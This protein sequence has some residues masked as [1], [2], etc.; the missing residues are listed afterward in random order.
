VPNLK[1]LYYFYVFAQE[2]STKEAAKRLGISSPALSNQLKHLESVL[3]VRLTHRVE[4]SIRM[5][6]CGE[7]VRTYVNRMFSIYEELQTQL[8]VNHSIESGVVRVGVC[9]DLGARFSFDLIFLLES[10]TSTFAKTTKVTFGASED[11]KVRFEEGKLDL[12]FGAFQDQGVTPETSLLHALEFPVRLFAPSGFD[13]KGDPFDIAKQKG[14]ALILPME[15]S[16]LRQESD[17]YIASKNLKFN[18]TIVCNSSGAIIQ[19][20]ERGAAFGFVPTPC[21]LDFKSARTLTSFGPMD[22]FWG[23]QVSVFVQ[24]KLKLP[25]NVVP[26]LAALFQEDKEFK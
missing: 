22:G 15:P 21:L 13:P 19:L 6:E 3:G 11:L 16:L 10:M 8:T 26:T 25:L 24:D 2:L 18:R 17:R 7:M 1:H 14:V 20:I 9:Q 4:G 12:I 5:T 23:H